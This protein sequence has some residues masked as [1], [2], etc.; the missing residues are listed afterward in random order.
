[1]IQERFLQSAINIRRKY[2]KVSNNLSIYHNRAE[3]MI[4]SLNQ[5]LERIENLK[6]DLEKKQNQKSISQDQ[7]LNELMSIIQS[8]EDEGKKLELLTEPMNKEIEKL[9]VEEQELYSQIIKSHPNLSEEQIIN[10]VK[11]RLEKE[12]LS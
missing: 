9:A 10:S 7:A 8:V 6:S 4:E 5:T 12:G 2:L 1:M 11:D 3:T